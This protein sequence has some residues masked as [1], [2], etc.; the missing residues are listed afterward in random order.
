MI[1]LDTCFNRN[2]KKIINDSLSWLAKFQNKDGSFYNWLIDEDRKKVADATIQA[3]RLWYYF[4]CEKFR[5]NIERGLSF[6][7]TN[8]AVEGGIYYSPNNNYINS[9]TSIFTL[10]TLYMIEKGKNITWMI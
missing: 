3:V 7:F 8:Q 2:Y 1:M 5:S 9:W 4:D 6:I 10:K